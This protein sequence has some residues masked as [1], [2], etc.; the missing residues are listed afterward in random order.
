MSGLMKFQGKDKI[1]LQQPISACTKMNDCQ[2]NY[3]D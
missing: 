1:D 3:E 2:F